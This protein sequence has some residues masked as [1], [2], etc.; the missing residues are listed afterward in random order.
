MAKCIYARCFRAFRQWHHS[1]LNTERNGDAIAN[2]IHSALLKYERN[3][4]NGHFNI[5]DWFGSNYYISNAACDPNGPIQSNCH[6]S[7][8]MKSMFGRPSKHKICALARIASLDHVPVV[9]HVHGMHVPLLS[10]VCP[11]MCV[12]EMYG[13]L[14]N[15]HS[16]LI[17]MSAQWQQITKKKY[18]TNRI[19]II[20]KNKT[21]TTKN[22][23]FPMKVERKKNAL[24]TLKLLSW[25]DSRYS[26]FGMAIQNSICI[27]PA[28]SYHPYIWS[29]IAWE[30][31]REYIVWRQLDQWSQT[32]LNP[33]FTY[34][35]TWVASDSFSSD[36]QN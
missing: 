30:R 20:I 21:T 34:N 28:R 8:S 35:F 29:R 32:I 6:A 5:V 2:L 16:A 33:R 10:N 1:L 24:R 13:L 3:Q 15:T 18:D 26:N 22:L 36:T 4:C 14:A 27:C 31:E 12:S 17:T 11:S 25:I 23:S 9:Y 7:W 19:I